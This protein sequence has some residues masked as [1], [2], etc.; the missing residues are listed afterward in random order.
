MIVTVGNTKGGVG[1]TTL[2]VNLAIA[3]ALAGRDVWLIDGDRQGTAQTAISIRAD[4]GYTPGIACATYPDGPTLR[5]QVQQQASKFDDIIIDAGGRDSTALRAALV[6]SDV[7]LVPFA[8]RSYDVWA[9]NDIASLVDEARSVRDG[10]RAVAILNCADPGESSTDN[11]DAAAAVAEIPQFEYLNT[12]IRRR[13]AFAN[14]AGQGLSV[15]EL[16]PTDRKAS[17]ELNA[18]ISALF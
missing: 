5:A 3:R 17:K 1:K 11:A 15:L 18:L 16:K 14:A 9:L 13:K 10:L 8:P 2:A 6:L 12:P 4:A 7:L